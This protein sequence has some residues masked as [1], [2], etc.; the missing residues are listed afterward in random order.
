MSED[1]RL[2]SEGGLYDRHDAQLGTLATKSR[3][4]IR[5]LSI[6]SRTAVL[7]AI[8]RASFFLLPS[9]VQT[10]LHPPSQPKPPKPIHPTA[11][12]DGMRGI[13]AFLVF[14]FHIS[15]AT[16]D[17]ATAWT[18][19]HR[20]LL[21]LPILRFFYHGPAMVSIFFVLSGYA[22]SYKPVKQMR[23]GE[24]DSLLKGLS[25]SVFRRAMRLYLP[26][27]AS[28]LTIVVIVRLG[29]YDW[30][31]ELAN[32]GKRL[33]GYRDRHAW[34][35]DT[36][37]E[38]LVHWGSSFL[39]FMNPFTGKRMYLDG[40][41]WTIPLEFVSL[42]CIGGIVDVLYRASIVLY[43]TQLGLCR[44]RTRYRMLIL[45]CIMAWAHY[46]DY[47]VV[48]LFYG[49]FLLAELD[50]RRSALAA[51]KTFSN[52]LSSPKPSMLWSV[53]Y[54]LVFI[55]GLYLGGQPEQRWEHA[56]GWMT[57]WSLIPSYIHDRHRYWTG[58]GALLLVWS[59]S[60]SPML[61]RIFNNR[62]TQYLGKISFS[63]Y[64]VHGFMIH[65]LYYSLLPVVWNIFGS[66]T[67]LQKEVSFGVALGIVSVFLVWVS[68]V[69]MRLV[70]TPSVKFARWLEG[71]C[72]AKA[73]ST[74]EEPAWRESSAMV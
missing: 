71:K 12:L 31:R 66:E 53:F 4:S 39:G 5:G 45:P 47:W 63:L 27:V 58:W 33:T 13:A 15:Y 48:L 68:D 38:Q 57:L 36:L 34:R 40:H 2:M 62:F 41:L 60:N 18:E 42:A 37:A 3:M 17:V 64:L 67:H 74:K 28:T 1:Q 23:S 30:T 19:G 16:H 26:C 55:G 49:G 10:S 7:H 54:T 51:S 6:P 43:A 9:F 8:K 72:V 20:G 46:A 61:Q 56:P 32:D 11:W 22:L 14:I 35:Y 44:L 52:T 25:S 21:R 65:T 70:D 59:T 69:F 24:T 50:I 73:K 29:M